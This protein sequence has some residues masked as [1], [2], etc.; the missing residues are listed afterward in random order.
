MNL[1]RAIMHPLNPLVIVPAR[2]ASTRLPNKPMANIHGTPMIVHAWRCAMH[3]NVGPVV[4]ACDHHD[5][6]TAI[7]SVGGKAVLT[8]THHSTGSDRIHEAA[9]IIDPNEQHSVIINIQG[10]MPLFPSHVVSLLMTPFEDASIDI[11]TLMQPH[12]RNASKVRAYTQPLPDHPWHIC[13]DFQ[14]RTMEYTHLGFY[15]YRR[16]ALS[17][18]VTLSPTHNEQDRSL[19]QM[20]ALD[21]G[22]TIASMTVDKDSVFLTVDTPADLTCAIETLA[23]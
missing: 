9:S 12:A 6:K 7:E 8:S 21:H 1:I 15:A 4:V 14:R 13:H 20:R 5:I 19:E 10:D 23:P 17:R 3:A 22:M 2:M 18:Y 16:S 11:T